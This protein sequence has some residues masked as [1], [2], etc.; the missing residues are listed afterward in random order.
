[1]KYFKNQYLLDVI[2]SSCFLAINGGGLV[3]NV[4]LLR[5]V[6]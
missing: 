3:V 1:M 4:C 5:F 2:R 6:F